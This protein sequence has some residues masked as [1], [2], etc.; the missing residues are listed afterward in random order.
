MSVGKKAFWEGRQGSKS[1]INHR[2]SLMQEVKCQLT[3]IGNWEEQGSK[4]VF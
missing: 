3:Q 4:K 2:E 1:H